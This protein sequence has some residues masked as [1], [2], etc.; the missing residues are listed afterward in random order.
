MAVL[1]RSTYQKDGPGRAKY[2]D[3]FLDHLHWGRVNERFKRCQKMC[4]AR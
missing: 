3:N 1:Y 2:I 4:A